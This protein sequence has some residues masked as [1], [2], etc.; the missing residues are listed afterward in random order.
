M[1]KNNADGKTNRTQL[2]K[3]PKVLTNKVSHALRATKDMGHERTKLLLDRHRSNHAKRIAAWGISNI[4]APVPLLEPMPIEYLYK[5]KNLDDAF[6]ELRH[7]IDGGASDYAAKEVGSHINRLRASVPRNRK[8]EYR[9][10]AEY[11]R[12]RNYEDSSNKKKL[13]SD[14]QQHFSV[15]ESTVR[16]AIQQRKLRKK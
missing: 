3:F 8:T 2:P 15:S 9:E 13:I 11:L 7:Y 14:A 16:R 1:K 10:I 12:I 4:G 6:N 5:I